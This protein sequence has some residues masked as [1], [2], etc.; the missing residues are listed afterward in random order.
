MCTGHFRYLLNTVWGILF[1]RIFNST[2]RT[3]FNFW[4]MADLIIGIRFYYSVTRFRHRNY[5]FLLVVVY[6][7]CMFLFIS[8]LLLKVHSKDLFCVSISLSMT[9]YIIV[10]IRNSEFLSKEKRDRFWSARI[11]QH[12]HFNFI[13]SKVFLQMEEIHIYLNGKPGINPFSQN[14][15]SISLWSSVSKLAD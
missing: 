1:K 9:L 2:A 6:K 13:N 10:W 11:A 4:W 3:L 15:R 12:N 5:S 14:Y 8:R 7:E